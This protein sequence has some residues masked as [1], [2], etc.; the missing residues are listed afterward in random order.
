MSVFKKKITI[1]AVWHLAKMCFLEF[2]SFAKKKKNTTSL[3]GSR[4]LCFCF[5]SHHIFACVF[6]HFKTQTTGFHTVILLFSLS[7]D[8]TLKNFC[9]LKCGIMLLKG[10]SFPYKARNLVALT[11]N[12][13]RKEAIFFYFLIINMIL[14]FFTEAK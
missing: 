14:A 13:G 1:F 9:H 11:P 2:Y 8:E 5:T 12:R 3:T 10:F 6:I 4:S 7:L